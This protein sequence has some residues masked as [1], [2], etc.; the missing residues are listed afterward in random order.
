[1]QVDR[2]TSARPQVDPVLKAPGFNWLKVQPF[3]AIGFKRQP[4]PIHLGGVEGARGRLPGDARPARRCIRVQ[5]KAVQV[6]IRLTL[7]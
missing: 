7:G 5:G 6:D 4:A 2:L 1:M 3:Q